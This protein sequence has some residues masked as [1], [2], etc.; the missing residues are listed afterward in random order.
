[1]DNAENA[2]DRLIEMGYLK[3][4]PTADVP[5]IRQELL[6][7]L[8]R[9][10]LDSEWDEEGVTRDRRGYPADSEDL[11]EGCLGEFLL[12]M[13]DVLQKEGVEL[14]EIEDQPEDCHYEVVINGQKHLIYDEDMVENALI[15]AVAT[16]RF[17]EIVNDLL[18]EAGSRE[19]LYGISGGNDCRAI[20]LTAEMYTFLHS[21]DLKIDPGWMP[22][23]SDVI[24]EKEG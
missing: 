17:L 22:Y 16:K 18:K 2:V 23:P 9:G 14:Y 15:W 13:K 1:M 21:P 3:Y 6:D 12:L 4:V 5:S 20:L 19:R 7:T 24:Q 8:K 11:A 10:Y